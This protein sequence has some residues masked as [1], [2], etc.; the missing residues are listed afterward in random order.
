M[1]MAN[2]VSDN[3]RQEHLQR[4]QSRDLD[5]AIRQQ[6]QLQRE[7][8]AKAHPVRNR[9]RKGARVIFVREPI[10]SYEQSTEHLQKQSARYSKNAKFL[11]QKAFNRGQSQNQPVTV[12]GES[13]ASQLKQEIANN[14]NSLSERIRQDF[15]N[16]NHVS[17]NDRISSEFSQMDRKIRKYW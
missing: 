6:E 14:Q 5:D 16:S 12:S 17:L 4:K 11:M 7:E 13:F 15:S 9:I 1:F 2:R 10:K 8:Y 3:Y